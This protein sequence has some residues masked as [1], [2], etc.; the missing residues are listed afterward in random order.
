MQSEPDFKP[1]TTL[2]DKLTAFAL[3]YWYVGAGLAMLAAL[4]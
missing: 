4:W 1:K 2:G 3:V